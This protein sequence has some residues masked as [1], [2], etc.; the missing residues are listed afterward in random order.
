MLIHNNHDHPCAMGIKNAENRT[1]KPNLHLVKGVRKYKK[2]ILYS[3]V[4]TCIFADY[5]DIYNSY[6]L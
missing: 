3:I 4:V 6:T 1:H 5:T 2:V